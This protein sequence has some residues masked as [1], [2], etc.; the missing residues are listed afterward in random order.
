MGGG[1][2][3]SVIFL[4]PP[5]WLP[6][7]PHQCRLNALWGLRD[8]MTNKPMDRLTGV[9]AVSYQ[10][11]KKFDI[12]MKLWCR[13]S[14]LVGFYWILKSLKVSFLGI[15]QAWKNWK[16]PFKVNHSWKGCIPQKHKC[17][18][19]QI[20]FL[21]TKGFQSISDFYLQNGGQAS[22]TPQNYFFLH[23]LSSYK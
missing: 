17:R 8:S 10:Q 7:W 23:F 3:L 2:T 20:F 19:D 13:C 11:K 1:G 22:K 18:T 15:N 6:F 12:I 9:G 21:A 5:C 16:D 14:L 4:R